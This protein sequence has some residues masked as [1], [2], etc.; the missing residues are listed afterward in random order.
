MS[1]VR[2]LAPPETTG[3]AC[4]E[5]D[6]ELFFPVSE[7]DTARIAQAKSVCAGCGLRAQC[8]QVALTSGDQGVWGGTTTAERAA[9]RHG[10]I[11]SETDE[12]RAA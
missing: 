9:L 7:Y 5:Q 10:V 3:P 4:A 12:V 8:L 11:E 6:P 1:S 2:R